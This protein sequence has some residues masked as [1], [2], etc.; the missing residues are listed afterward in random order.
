MNDPIIARKITTKERLDKLNSLYSK[1]PKGKCDACAKCCNE[2]VNI[3]YFEFVNIIENGLPRID[4]KAFNA[5]SERLMRYY[6]LEWVKSQHCP[7]L[8]EYKNCLIYEVRPLPC[9][10]FGTSIQE[11]YMKNYQRIATQNRQVAKAIKLE[12]GHF[13]SAKVVNKEISFCES[14]VPEK[15]LTTEEID[16]LYG[17][18][19]NLDGQLYFEGLIDD[20]KMNGNLV[21]WMIDWLIEGLTD[22]TSHCRTKLVDKKWLYALKKDCLSTYKA[23]IVN[24]R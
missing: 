23:E 9:R 24:R 18:L 3:S 15:R 10:I 14:F 21:G 8:D 12:T 5:L 19:I 7:F 11:D 20:S 16:A 17:Q 1:V 4:E 13:P 6:L 22:E 2:S